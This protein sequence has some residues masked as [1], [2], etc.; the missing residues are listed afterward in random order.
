MNWENHVQS[1]ITHLA[2]CPEV[3]Y[4]KKIREDADALETD[5][6]AA[7]IGEAAR[8]SSS[9]LAIDEKECDKIGCT[10]SNNRVFVPKPYES[11]WK[12]YC[13]GGWV[14]VD[15]PTE[16]DGQ[17]LP[18]CIASGVQELFDRASVSFGML[19]GANR[20]AIKLLQTCA[21]T[22]IAQQWLPKLASGD[23]GA[24]ICISEAEAGSDVGRIRTKADMNQDG[25][26]RV[27]GEKM[28]ISFGDHQLTERIG[29]FL[30]ARTE[31]DIAGT[32]GL[33]LFLVSNVNDDGSPNTVHVRG[34][35]EK[36]G[37]HSSPTCSLGFE[38]A[39]ATLLGKRGHG[40]PML[41]NMIIAM[42]LNVSCQGIGLATAAW[43]LANEYA[44]VR[45]QGGSP[46][47][48]PIPII[49]HAD[50][51]INL[52]SME[53]DIECQRGLNITAS[54]LSD[55]KNCET[56]A[57]R[58]KTTTALLGFILPILKNASSELAFDTSAK[59]ILVLGGAG[60]TQDWALERLLRDSRVLAIFEGTTGIQALDL[61]KRH[62][63]GNNLGYFE[64][65]KRARSEIGTANKEHVR[66][67]LDM[68]E[69]FE[70][71]AQWLSHPNR[72]K[73]E[74]ESGASATLS[75]A[76]LCARGWMA[77]RMINMPNNSLKTKRFTALGH[78][79]LQK[80][81]GKAQHIQTAILRGANTLQA[82]D[83]AI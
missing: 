71:A 13:Q 1:I 42:R 52:L 74:I 63:I 64:F 31:H 34:L 49:E 76:T 18:V 26:W 67:A 53:S 9:I 45:R 25:E 6:M 59:A 69:R 17:N 8:F 61:V 7:I 58:L 16:N 2:Y 55:L 70:N 82:F 77:M 21:D 11:S 29:H 32:R 65:M 27:S 40:L 14:A 39:H 68:F 56:D 36:L 4:L 30:L 48:P 47:S 60:F 22:D 15:A 10:F 81:Q 79:W 19:P 57:E 44:H 46:H 50:V 75:L 37:L 33:S 24:T 43:S 23:W 78:Y 72:T 80:N 3:K 66:T 20:G 54:A 51:R 5:M 38:K 73:M 62:I 83:K 41:F 35:E 12:Q 28:W